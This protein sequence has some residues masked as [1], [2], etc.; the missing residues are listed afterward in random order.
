MT[1]QEVIDNVR[2]ELLEASA[3]FWTDAELLRWLNDG[4]RDFVNKVRGIDKVSTVSTVAGR[5]R[6][7]LPASFLASK[8]V[9]YNDVLSDGT[10][11]WKRLQPTT[12]EKLAQE[13][14]GF[15][16]DDEAAR[17]IPRAYT[18]FANEL[19][20]TPTPR[21]DGKQIKMFHKGKA[22][23]LTA[24]SQSFTIDDSMAD[25]LKAYVLWQAWAKEKEFQL[26]AMWEQKYKDYV[27]EGRRFYNRLIGDAAFQI[28]VESD[29]PFGNSTLPNTWTW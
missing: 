16:S 18:I 5:N 14:P 1:G 15:L 12:L 29:Q 25:G 27:G 10:D 21:D 2:S 13:N 23:P 24:L 20:V 19:Y 6:Y 26:A 3:A 22:V 9:F 17:S 8:A 28:D 7:P 4:E 11:Q